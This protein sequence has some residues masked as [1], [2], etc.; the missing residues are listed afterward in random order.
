MQNHPFV[1]GN[2]RTGA[3]AARVFLLMIGFR[4]E[5]EQD[6]YTQ[7]VLDVASGTLDKDGVTDFFRKHGRKS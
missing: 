6:G 4:F 2:K 1:D 7:L 3:I 5:P